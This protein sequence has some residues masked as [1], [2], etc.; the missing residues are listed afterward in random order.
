MHERYLGESGCN[1]LLIAWASLSYA[2]S[3]G[4]NVQSNEKLG[5]WMR[6]PRVLWWQSFELARVLE[7]EKAQRGEVAKKIADLNRRLAHVNAAG[8]SAAAT[9]LQA[10]RTG[11]E[12][13]L[14]RHSAQVRLS[15]AVF[16]RPCRLGEAVTASVCDGR[17]CAQPL[18]RSS[19]CPPTHRSPG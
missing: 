14:Q 7:G 1:D 10:E 6:C 8:D 13:Q 11:L 5:G 17:T 4:E 16:L 9:N 19:P 12:S 3:L 15:L 2:Q 18:E